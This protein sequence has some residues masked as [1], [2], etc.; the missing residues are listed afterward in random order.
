MNII[1]QIKNLEK[2]KEQEEKVLQKE[3]E[4]HAEIQE[5]HEKSIYS[6]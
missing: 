4:E 6:I 3:I 2:A 5:E 1:T